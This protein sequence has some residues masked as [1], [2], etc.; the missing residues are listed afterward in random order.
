MALPALADSPT[1]TLKD[2]LAAAYRDNAT[3]AAQRFQLRGTDEQ[4]PQA[5]SGW[6][7]SVTLNTQL[8]RGRQFFNFGGSPVEDLTNR[9]YALQV[10]QPIYHASTAPDID[11]AKATIEGGQQQLSSIEQQQLLSAALAYL[12]VFRDQGEV[13]LNRSLVKVLTVNRHN[14]DSTFRAGTAT[15]TDTSQAA[16]RLSGA[17]SGELGAEAQLATSLA[18]FRD[19]VGRDAGKLATPG[20]LGE[21]PPTEDEAASLA[22]SRNPTLLSAK[23]Q[24]E[25]AQHQVEVARGNLLPKLDGI[26]IAEHEDELFAKGVRLNSAVVGVQATVPLYEAGK[27]Y[28]EVRAAHEAVSQADA[29]VTQTERDLRAQVGTAWN[30]LRAARAQQQNDH[31]QIRANEV[32]LRDTEREVEAGTRTRLDALNAQQELFGSRLNLVIA[33]H[34]T[35]AA[36]FQ[37]EAAAGNFTPEALGLDVQRYDPAVHLDA[38]RDKW[39]GTEPPPAK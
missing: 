35:V 21:V 12:D 13:E 32:A 26:A 11:R 27:T 39:I 3:I 15:E 36:S 10:T 4:L 29:E 14:V 25:A 8:T 16:A 18:H 38:V 31:D 24:L 28:S 33:E 5:L 34:D 30:A 23:K 19:I 2:T 17:V 6:R 20:V 7:P 9:V 37:L 22:L 1:E